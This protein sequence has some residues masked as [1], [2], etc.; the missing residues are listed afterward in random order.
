MSVVSCSVVPGGCNLCYAMQG[1]EFIF[2]YAK[3]EPG[4][5]LVM[6]D[7]E[8]GDIEPLVF[9]EPW[10]SELIERPWLPSR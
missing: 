7:A 5:Q 3:G 1:V 10:C 9:H 2:D 8:P 6:C 4:F